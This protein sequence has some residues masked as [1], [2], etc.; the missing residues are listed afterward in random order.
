[1][2][3]MNKIEKEVL[4]SVCQDIDNADDKIDALE[5]LHREVKKMLKLK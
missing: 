4:L 3:A 2:I 5:R 1:M